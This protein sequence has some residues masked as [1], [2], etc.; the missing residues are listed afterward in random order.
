MKP[1]TT[2]LEILKLLWQQEPRTAKEIH[3]AIAAR[4][5]WSYS[6]TRKTLERMG[7]KGLLS[8]GEQGNKKSYTARVEKV[9]TLAAYAQEF[10]KNVLELDGPL[11]V[12]MFADSRL[13]ESQ[14]LEELEHLLASLSEQDKRSQ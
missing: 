11:P 12:A 1:N 5:N 9:P 13:I 14:E 3:D 2:E 6:S 4:F 8:I 7:D 10:A